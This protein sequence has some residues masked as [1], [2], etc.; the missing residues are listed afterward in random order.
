MD[1]WW[2]F[3]FQIG[4]NTRQKKNK[5]KTAGFMQEIV[6]HRFRVWNTKY[7]FIFWRGRWTQYD[8]HLAAPMCV[9]SQQREPNTPFTFTWYQIFIRCVFS[10]VFFIRRRTKEIYS[11]HKM[12]SRMNWQCEWGKVFG[13]LN[14]S[15]WKVER[16]FFWSVVA[17]AAAG[18]YPTR[19]TSSERTNAHGLRVS[20]LEEN[21]DFALIGAVDSRWS[22]GESVFRIYF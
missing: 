18:V 8:I 19:R 21:R 7:F 3:H 12:K 6:A 15:I 22:R 5:K 9:W 14:I 2:S 1:A 17:R 16:W 20:A 13:F 10:G 11:V 4:S